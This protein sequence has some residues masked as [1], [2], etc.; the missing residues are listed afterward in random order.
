MKT[1]NNLKPAMA[2]IYKH[3]GIKLVQYRN[4]ILAL[5]NTNVRVH[6]DAKFHDP[7]ANVKLKKAL[8]IAMNTL[9]GKFKKENLSLGG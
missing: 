7:Q 4:E 5:N 8:F 6:L 9:L 1:S 2:H 3:T